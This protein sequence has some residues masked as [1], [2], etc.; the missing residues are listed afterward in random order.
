[1]QTPAPAFLSPECPSKRYLPVI[2]VKECSFSRDHDL[3]Q[4]V[5]ARPFRGRGP[6]PTCG[7]QQGCGH[8]KTVSQVSLVP[9]RYLAVKTERYPCS[10]LWCDTW[11]T[12]DPGHV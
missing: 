6:L 2:T 3:R 7:S 1:M 12:G 10:L 11:R 5:P 4:Y 8:H 9:E